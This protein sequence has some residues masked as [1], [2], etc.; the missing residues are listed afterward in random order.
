M[1][2]LAERYKK[3]M[4]LFKEKF[5]KI[6]DFIHDSRHTTLMKDAVHE[7]FVNEE[8]TKIEDIQNARASQT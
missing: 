7:K 8:S 5:K 6:N 3:E 4:E 1:Q 2:D